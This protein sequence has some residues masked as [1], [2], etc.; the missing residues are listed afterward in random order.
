M[1]IR[2]DESGNRWVEMQLLLPGTPEQVWQALATG[3]GYTAW[4]TRTEIEEKVGGRM[5]FDFGPNGS[6]SGE[7]TTWQPPNRFAYVE[8]EW[9][10][11]A[12]PIATEI[13]ITAR[14]GD[15]CVL[16]M[17]HS[18]F[19]E[20]DQWDDQ[21][22]GFEMGWQGFF[23]ALQVYLRHFAGRSSATFIS[24]TS[25]S[26]S[27]AEAWERLTDALGLAGANAGD[28]REAAAGAAPLAGVVEY[29]R[30]EA[31]QRFLVLRLDTPSPGIALT[32]T[33]WMDG[34]SHVSLSLYL[35]G[36]DA[37]AA[38]AALQPQWEQWLGGLFAPAA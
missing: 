32:G 18:L 26:D 4:F 28:R 5:Y 6:S 38:I 33:Y 8:R 12:P 27:Q 3:P 9:N 20:S 24:R 29:L 25:S 34:R 16:R 23:E 14:S 19:T 30:Q 37:P 21:I 31:Q 10:P 11:G 1:P 22:E 2:K 35:Y 17:V 7:V 15:R 36:D 13:T